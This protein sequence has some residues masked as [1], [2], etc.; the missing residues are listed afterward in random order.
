LEEEDKRRKTH[1]AGN[2]LPEIKNQQPSKNE[3]KT[4]KNAPNADQ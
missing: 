2:M 4:A 3:K 1:D